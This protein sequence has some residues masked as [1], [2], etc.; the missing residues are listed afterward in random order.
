MKKSLAVLLAGAVALAL[1]PACGDDDPSPSN[2]DGS[3]EPGPDAS[4]EAVD[5]GAPADAAL[6]AG[7]DAGLPDSGGTPD[8]GAPDTGA[9]DRTPPTVLTTDPADDAVDV[10]L[11]R[12]ITVRFSEPVDPALL[13]PGS[14]ELIEWW[15]GNPQ[16]SPLAGT[17]DTSGNPAIVFIPAAPFE[18][19][20]VYRFT[21]KAGVRDLAGNALASDYVIVFDAAWVTPGQA[22]AVAAAMPAA[23]ATG[24]PT[25]TAV[26]L[27][28][29]KRMAQS[30]VVSPTTVSVYPGTDSA[31]P[32]AM[33]RD[34]TRDPIFT[35][36]PQQPLAANTL[37]T[38]KVKS[39][40]TGAKD[41]QGNGLSQDFLATFTTGA[42]PDTGALEVVSVDPA[43]GASGVSAVPSVTVTFNKPV[44]PA[45]LFLASTGTAGTFALSRYADGSFPEAGTLDFSANPAVKF[46]LDPA[47]TLDLSRD[48]HVRVA[49]G[50][51]GA[52]SLSGAAMTA[53]YTSSFT[54]KPP[55]NPDGTIA[56]LRAASGVCGIRVKGVTMTYVREQPSDWKGFFIQK[57]K[58]GPAIFVL[59]GGFKPPFM[60]DPVN[61]VF[62]NLDITVS[63]VGENEGFKQ[64]L[65]FS[66]TRNN[67][68]TV[69]LKYVR[70]NLVQVVG[71]EEVGAEHES[72]YLQID[73]T[74][75]NYR[76]GGSAENREFDLTWGTNRKVTMKVSQFGIL[77]PLGLA[78]G[79]RVRVTAPL[80]RDD[81]GYFVKPYWYT[82]EGAMTA[83]QLDDPANYLQALDIV[84][85]AP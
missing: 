56:D 69:G 28:F 68:A 74:L 63:R 81:N 19:G 50:A 11:D 31:S 38:I 24:V 25:D 66:M 59:T 13:S 8:A 42:G 67:G 33:N 34:A 58:A 64:V 39:G 83:A 51:T 1:L 36:K 52:K 14:F 84:K 21:V 27:V 22:P 46:T 2:L 57:E 73:G 54:T 26:A 55:D 16:G 35:F 77:E 49:G 29:S 4:S 12:R 9:I 43:P 62:P 80:Q 40:S 30:S 18:V 10:P 78:S 70:E 41:E 45:K 6:P 17:L 23:G 47:S 53:S 7:E 37:Y 71:D 75:K 76:P 85:L 79:V 82:T 5:S 65:A 20:D 72:E 44:N 3:V 60:A 32:V 61:D 15:D 48:Y